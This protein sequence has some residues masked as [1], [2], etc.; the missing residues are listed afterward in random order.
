MLRQIGH[1]FGNICFEGLSRKLPVKISN[2][3]G[4]KL[5]LFIILIDIEHMISNGTSI[6]IKHYCEDGLRLYPNEPELLY[7]T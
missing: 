1:F 4:E 7:R 2:I 6:A 5:A 3:K